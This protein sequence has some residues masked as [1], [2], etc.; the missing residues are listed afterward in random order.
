MTQGFNEWKTTYYSSPQL[1][2]MV[3][4]FP[5]SLGW[6]FIRASDWATGIGIVLIGVLVRASGRGYPGI[7]KSQTASDIAA[8]VTK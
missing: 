2:N 3:S 6:T 5:S 8:S 1:S 7:P 4:P